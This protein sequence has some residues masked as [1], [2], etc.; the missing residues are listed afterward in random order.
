MAA[1]T[2]RDSEQLLAHSFD[3]KPSQTDLY[4]THFLGNDA[5]ITFL[6]SLEQRPNVHAL[7]LFPE[8]AN[9]NRHIF[10]PSSSG[11]RTVDEVYALFDTKFSTRRYDD[12]ATN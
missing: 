8:A 2:V 6:R 4:L 3:R 1:E 9:S 12:F 11:P 5:A 7:E 10:H